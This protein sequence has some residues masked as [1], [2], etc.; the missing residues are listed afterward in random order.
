MSRQQVG[1][2]LAQRGRTRV[3]VG[4]TFRSDTPRENRLLAAAAL[5]RECARACCLNQ[6]LL[7]Y[8]Q[9]LITQ[10][11][12]AAVCIRHHSLQ[13][14]LCQLILMGLDR[15]QSRDMVITHERIA[16]MPGVRREGVTEAASSLRDDGLMHTRPGH[17]VVLDRAGLEQRACECYTVVKREYDR[18]LGAKGQVGTMRTQC[19][20][21]RNVAAAKELAE[22]EF[23]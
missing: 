7:H 14:R 20:E 1:Q 4:R 8:T 17:F 11:A 22:P 5:E 15:Q 18:L 23:I 3:V 9:V 21:P 16:E 13:Q 12:Q 10:I 19:E 6:L 2:T